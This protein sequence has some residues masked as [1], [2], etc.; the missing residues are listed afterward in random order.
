Y[1]GANNQSATS[2][3]WGLTLRNAVTPTSVLTGDDPA[4]TPTVTDNLT[5][6]AAADLIKGL[7]G[8]DALL[9]KDGD[10]IIEGGA[11]N[12]ILMGGL[13]AD[14]LDGGAGDDL[15]YGSSTGSID[16]AQPQTPGDPII[17][18]HGANWYRSSTGPDADGFLNDFLSTNVHRDTQAGDAGNVID[19]GAGND[20]VYAGT[21]DDL[22]HGGDGNDQIT[23][24]AGSDVL[25]GD[26]GDDRIYG[27]GPAGNTASILYTPADQ[28]GA[29]FIDGGAGN[30]LLFGQGGDDVIYG[31][32]GNDKLYGDDRD[33]INTPASANG[34]DYLDGEEG[35]DTLV[36][37]GRA[38]TLYGGSGNDTLWGD[39]G[40]TMPTSAS[41]LDPSVSGDDY[42]DGEEGDDTL[43]GQGGNDTLY[44]GI[45]NDMLQGDDNA[46]RLAGQ[47]HG[48]DYLDGEDGNDTLIGGGGNDTLYGG[49]G[50]DVLYGDDVSLDAQFHGDDYLDGE[51]GDDTLIGGGGHDTMFGSA[52]AD[53]L[54]GGEGNDQL[55]GGDGND[56]LYGDAGDDTAEGGDGDDLI[57]GG[58]GK[59]VLSGGEGI[60]LLSGDAGDDILSGD[61]GDDELQGGDGNDMLHGGLGDDRLFGQAGDDVLDGGEGN[62]YLDGGDGND[63]LIGGSG[64]DTLI[65]GLGDNSLEG[66]GGN[67]TLVASE[68]GGTVTMAG[69]DGDDIYVIKSGS[70]NVTVTDSSGD[71]TVAFAAGLNANKLTGS[72]G[73]NGITLNIGGGSSVTVQGDVKYQFADGTVLS[74]EAVLALITPGPA[75]GPAPAPTPAPAPG[76]SPAPAPAPAPVPQPTSTTTTFADGSYRVTVDDGQGNVMSTLYSQ[77][78]RK[79]SDSWTRADNSH[80]SDT[81]K[82]D[83]TSSGVR[84]RADG[85][86]DTYVND[87]Q[88][89]TKS[90][91]HNPGSGA[92]G[93]NTV[94]SG[95][96]EVNGL[97]SIT[98]LLNAAGDKVSESWIHPNGVAG[99]DIVSALDFSG[100]PNFAAHSP[101][102]LLPASRANGT[103]TLI[104]W[105]VPLADG[106]RDPD[107]AGGYFYNRN[108]YYGSEWWLPRDEGSQV[109]PYGDSIVLLNESDT[110][111]QY[112]VNSTWGWGANQQ[113]HGIE[114]WGLTQTEAKAQWQYQ[115]DG[116]VDKPLSQQQFEQIHL[117]DNQLGISVREELRLDGKKYVFDESGVVTL[118]VLPDARTPFTLTIAGNILGSYGILKDDGQGNITLTSY[119]AAGV[120]ASDEWNHN[121]GSNG[122]DVYNADGSSVGMSINPEGVIVRFTTD[123]QGN[124]TSSTDFPGIHADITTIHLAPPPITPSPLPGPRTAPPP[125]P[126]GPPAITSYPDGHGGTVTVIYSQGDASA[127]HTDAHGNV[128]KVHTDPGLSAGVLVGGSTFGWNYDIAGTPVSRYVDNGQGSRVTYFYDSQGHVTGHSTATTDVQELGTTLTFGAD[129]LQDGSTVRTGPAAGQT[130]TKTFNA[131]GQLTGRSVEITYGAHDSVTTTYDAQGALV[132]TVYQ[133]PIS[134]QQTTVTS[135]N[136]LGACTGVI[137][138]TTAA[139]GYITTD[140]YDAAGHPTGSV[141][142]HTDSTG[143]IV[144]ARYD[145][146]GALIGYVNLATDAMNDTV[147]TSYDAHGRRVHEDVLKPNGVQV[148]TSYNA[149]GSSVLRTVAVDGTFSI[150]TRG[151]SGDVAST[152]YNA[153]GARISG[154]WTRADGSY[155]TET[156]NA[157]GTSTGQAAYADGTTSSSVTN[158]QG[159]L[160]VTH[161]ASGGATVTGTSVTTHAQGETR[162]TD[163]NAQGAKTDDSWFRTDG[164]NGFDI[165]NADGS[166]SGM[167]V[168]A[169]GSYDLFSTDTIGITT[170]QHYSAAGALTGTTIGGGA[171][172]ANHA[173]TVGNAINSQ[174]AVEDQAWTFSLPAGAFIDEDAGDTLTYSAKLADGT[175]LPSWIV[176]DAQTRSFQGKPLNADVG[177]LSVKVTATDSKG[178]SASTEFALAVANV[179]DAPTVGQTIASQTATQDQTWTYNVPVGTFVDVDANDTL[180]YSVTLANG[181]ALP[182]WLSFDAATRTFS[183]KP[184]NGDVGHLTLTLTA[185]DTAGASVSTTLNLDVANVNDAPVVGQALGNQ[186]ATATQVWAFTLPANA[187]YDVDAG[188]VLT[189]SVKM[190][191][192]SALPSWLSFNALTRVFSGTP[193]IVDAGSLSLKITATDASGA[194]ASQT[195][196]VSVAGTPGQTITGTSAADKLIGG[197]GPDRIDGLAG[198]DTMT[199]GDGDDTYVVD[200][201][202]DVVVEAA[203]QGYDRIETSVT[204][205]LPAN[206]EAM[207][208]TGTANINA[209]GNALNNELVGNAGSNKLDGG[210]GADRMMGG[211]G[212]DTYTVDDSGDTVVELPDEGTDAVLSS[213]SYTLGENVENLTLTGS[214]ALT[215]TGNALANVMTANATGSTLRGM[216]G[217]DTLRGGAGADALY[218]GEGNDRL[219]GGAGADQMLGGAGNDIYLVEDLG[220]VVTELAGEGTDTVQSSLSYT[221]GANLENLTLTGTVALNGTGNELNNVLT[222]TDAGGTLRGLAGNDTLRGGLAADTLYGGDGNDRLDGGAGADQMFGEAGD[223]VY[224]VDTAGDTVTEQVGEGSDTVQSSISYVLGA[225]VEKL[226]LTGTAALTGTGNELD[227]VMTANAAGSTL[228]GMAGNDTLRGGVAGDKLNGGDG[229]DRLDGGAG[230]DQ[231]TGGAGNDTYVVDD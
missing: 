124:V 29:D 54:Q 133:L 132:S 28:H 172:P 187:F 55:D 153:L 155:G 74:T 122:I 114:V 136:A 102:R 38:D 143:T 83:G 107:G 167:T 65:G 20:I 4:A 23:G 68:G 140:N 8:D 199:G 185:T 164:S 66:G 104:Q 76:P 3:A 14:K 34:K 22:V 77:A 49:T 96:T 71:N 88:G 145:A 2:N 188:D 206:V 227:N 37:G 113:D 197:A 169:N 123:S 195:F 56:R 52:G 16:A 61:A 223:D 204:Y 5:G 98:T 25:L 45:G 129:G 156:F 103:G 173:P 135:Y 24:M 147:I 180:G 119:D 47:Y 210:A 216:A 10:D 32:I 7:T 97:N 130:E 225:N 86:Y 222:G 203:S 157:D 1:H 19:A 228:W 200:N 87:G 94:V 175:A 36:G 158:A 170:T 178:L 163:F 91:F 154:S 127:Y 59:D 100:L 30:D 226:T 82:A 142:A 46:L 15:I 152:H 63:V 194:T 90:T 151:S 93:A 215:G 53:E 176:F 12:D 141:I 184:G 106:S 58:D 101:S 89:Q 121:D 224:V 221:L 209:T 190:A 112:A 69:G 137:V 21:G 81:F 229:D 42:L 43:I 109:Q 198:A 134:A 39:G 108:D 201:A 13:G 84:Y 85:S 62:D 50:N 67:D 174:S 211:L 105:E 217:N 191:D 160:T 207:T 220:D 78:G 60:D 161:Y 72:V 231:L 17:V 126:P 116:G 166:S 57:A 146:A 168:A 138:T 219:D 230:A 131:Q 9:G 35:D 148:S 208:L 159:Q 111:Y 202:K 183:G 41:Y 186:S 18:A 149:D 95:I 128:S 144:T 26:A 192:G 120:K 115:I 31:G 79:L 181:D 213:I 218:G 177:S 80:G 6:T 40:D 171:P 212:N 44:G 179:N 70:G 214:A 139:N 11:G 196:S 27:D 162:T 64:N 125:P 33:P 189:Y 110:I 205:T 182:D 165:W 150:A 92:P 51:E 117:Y 48:N 118:T 99:T 75:P 73:Q 193:R